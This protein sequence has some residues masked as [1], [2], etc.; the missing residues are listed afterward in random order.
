[1]NRQFGSTRAHRIVEELEGGLKGGT[2]CRGVGYRVGQAV[3]TPSKQ[4]GP[5]LLTWH[6]VDRGNF[7][8]ENA[9]QW[10]EMA[11]LSFSGLVSGV[12]HPSNWTP[13]HPLP[14]TLVYYAT[15]CEQMT[16]TH[17]LG[18]DCGFWKRIYVIHIS[19]T[20]ISMY[21]KRTCFIKWHTQ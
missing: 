17:F 12:F 16:K 8:Q 2:R 13:H 3:M 11:L 21:R 18:R 20:E 15:S 9:S 14:K 10:H 7:I 6:K 4:R 5:S 19:T 1:M